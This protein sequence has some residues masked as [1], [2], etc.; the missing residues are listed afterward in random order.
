[1]LANLKICYINFKNSKNRGASYMY[2][3]ASHGTED[4]GIK[5]AAIE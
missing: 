3:S 5:V 1:M 4:V 2:S